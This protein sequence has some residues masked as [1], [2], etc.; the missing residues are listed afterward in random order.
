ML[1]ASIAGAEAQTLIDIFSGH[2]GW[3]DD[4]A[5]RVTHPVLDSR[6]PDIG[7]LKMSAFSS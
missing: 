1:Q 7:V 4:P 3:S 5:G 2:I 6:T